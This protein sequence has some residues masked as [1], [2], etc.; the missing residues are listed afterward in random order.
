[1]TIEF[2]LIG[3]G[4]LPI[5]QGPT[6]YK[7]DSIGN[8]R[9]WC[10]QLDSMGRYR[11][12]SGLA[13]GKQA[14]SGWTL[15][16]PRS[17]PTVKEQGKFEVRS[18]YK[19]QLDREYHESP[20]TVS[21]P[22]MI[23]PMLA[24]TYDKW[25][26]IGYAQPK[27]DGIR[28]IMTAEGMFT[29]QGQPIIAVPHLHAELRDLFVTFPDLVLDGELYNHDLREDFGA[30]SSIVRKKN[31]TPEQLQLAEEVM[32][33]HVY[34]HVDTMLDFG[35]RQRELVKWLAPH[36]GSIVIVP[37]QL[38]LTQQE[39]DDAYGEFVSL[40][41][42][43]GMYRLDKPYELGRRSKN[44]LKR[45]DFI[46]EEFKVLS[47]DEGKGNWAGAAKRMTLL[48]NNDGPQ[49][50]FGAGIRGSY[51]AGQ[52][53]LE[54]GQPGDAA[55][56]TCRFFMRSPDGVPRFPVVIDYHPDGRKD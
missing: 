6:L 3:G 12:L 53:L 16:V 11:T 49:D 15:P 52:R 1:M 41:Y 7:L 46:T 5:Y 33:Y 43:G 38:C 29:R 21:K 37:T 44:L 56:A 45:K 2:E 10:M 13:D 23:E 8:L 35:D 27:L 48:N 40:G 51:A 32:Q 47:I 55:V 14:V 25:P 36:Q 22:K 54:R 24:K 50:V 26:G 28:C 20:D 34:D 42:E 17:C 31:P 39:A 30:I 4:S 19:H 9:T 18:Q